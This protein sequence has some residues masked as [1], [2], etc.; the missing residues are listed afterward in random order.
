[1]ETLKQIT[2]HQHQEEKSMNMNTVTRTFIHTFTRTP[3]WFAIAALALLLLQACGTTNSSDP[4][5]NTESQLVEDL[6]ALGENGVFTL[7]NL[8]TGEAT[9]DSTSTNWDI[10]FRG[11]TLI[12]N[13]GSSG[14]GQGGV[15]LLDLP[16]DDVTLAPSEGYQTDSTDNY[17]I[18][19]GSGTGWYNYTGEG[20]PPFAILPRENVTLIIKTANGSNYAKLEILSY[21]EGN[22]DPTSDEFVNIQTRSASRYYTFRYVVQQTEDLREF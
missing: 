10:G 16:F 11:T 1:L 2:D 15:V 17:A 21:Y 9:T 5:S 3:L 12:F 8:R 13:S 6:A 14:P 4:V 19:T 20:F 18:S 7:F 22:P